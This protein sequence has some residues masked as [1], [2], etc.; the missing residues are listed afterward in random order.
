MNV[1]IT[2]RGMAPQETLCVLVRR[3]LELVALSEPFTSCKVLLETAADEDTT[4]TLRAHIELRGSPHGTRILV[5]ARHASLVV[6]IQE[7]FA[8]LTRKP[9][10]PVTASGLPHLRFRRQ[11]A[12]PQR[13]HAHAHARPR[14]RGRWTEPPAC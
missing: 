10:H 2:F 4:P 8:R 9:N 7:A 3:Q 12:R 11:L 13:E 5:Q 14:Q 6:A 1:E